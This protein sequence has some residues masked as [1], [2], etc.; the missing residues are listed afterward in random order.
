MDKKKPGQSFDEKLK[1][2]DKVFVLF[3]A[4]WCPFCRAFAPAFE[5]YAKTNP[6]GCIS[7]EIGERPDLFEKYYIDYYPA[8]ILFEKGKVKKRLDSKPGIGLDKKQLT[9][10]VRKS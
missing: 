2:K 5:E 9:E 8:V 4:A 7:V 6:K 3:H 10:L 1:G